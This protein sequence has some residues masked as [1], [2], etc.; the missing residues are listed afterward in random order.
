[1]FVREKPKIRHHHGFSSLHFIGTFQRCRIRWKGYT[2]DDD[3]W[4]PLAALENC[5]RLVAE[6]DQ[7]FPFR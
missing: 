2:V 3:T 7:R 1:M 5:Q 4:E 6:Y